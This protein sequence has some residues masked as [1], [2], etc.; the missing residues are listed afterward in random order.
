MTTQMSNDE[1]LAHI[2]ERQDAMGAF[3]NAS[4]TPTKA[5]VPSAP[6]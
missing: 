3:C 1:R 6:T 4:T 2:E 5:S